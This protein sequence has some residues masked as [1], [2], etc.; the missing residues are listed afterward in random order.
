MC[1]KTMMRN[2]LK[3]LLAALT[4][5]CVLLGC[6]SQKGSRKPKTL[7]QQKKEALEQYRDGMEE[8]LAGNY[9]EAIELFNQVSRLPSYIKY[10]S[11]ARLRGADAVLLKEL[12]ESA[13]LMYES[14]LKQY[15]GHPE[16]GYASYRIGQA[17]FIQIPSDWFLAPPVYERQQAHLEMA[18]KA[19][20]KFIREY[21]AHRLIPSARHMLNKC[22]RIAFDHELY[23][24]RFYESRKKY[25]GVVQRLEGLFQDFPAQS[26]TEENVLMLANAYEETERFSDATFM[27]KVYLERF[28]KGD[29]RSEVKRKLTSLHRAKA[30]DSSDDDSTKGS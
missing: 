30:V 16:S 6:A 1:W 18:Q 26:A 17:Y 4:L 13:I 9:S 25:H 29:D 28:P 8:L 22:D 11:L 19:L 27:Y 2:N 7:E 23:V 5:L 12:H 3:T 14:F 21:P 10:S 20:R 24:A 15:E